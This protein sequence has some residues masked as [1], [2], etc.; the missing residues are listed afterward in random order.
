MPLLP[1]YEPFHLRRVNRLRRG[2]WRF[3]V[4]S[5]LTH[6]GRPVALLFLHFRDAD[7]ARAYQQMLVL[8]EDHNAAFYDISKLADRVRIL[9]LLQPGAPLPVYISRVEG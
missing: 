7:R 8:Q 9:E 2:G 3:L 1:E 4:S 6:T 5:T